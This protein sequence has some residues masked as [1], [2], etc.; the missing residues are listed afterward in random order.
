MEYSKTTTA[1]SQVAELM[2]FVDS[3]IE[4]CRAGR[5]EKG[6]EYLRYVAAREGR[7]L[8]QAGL[9]L[10]YLGCSMARVQGRKEEAIALCRRAVK[11]E[12]YQPENWANL[13][14]VLILSDRRSEAIEAV[15]QGLEIDPQFG[16]LLK[17]HRSL[18]MRRRPILGFLP[19]S[20]PLNHVLGFLRSQ[21]AR[22]TEH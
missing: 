11:V 3:G 16:R 9:F 20:N 22:Q 17:L 8:D 5:W 14:E 21:L 19:R 4:H 7:G 2:S 1:H 10:S 13:A 15:E 12:F 18:G 6:V